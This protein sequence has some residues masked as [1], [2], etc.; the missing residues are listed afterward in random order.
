MNTFEAIMMMM[1][2]DCKI[3]YTKHTKQ[4]TYCSIKENSKTH[5]AKLKVIIDD[6]NSVCELL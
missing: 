3:K 5:N 4:K 6:Q 2:N 1:K